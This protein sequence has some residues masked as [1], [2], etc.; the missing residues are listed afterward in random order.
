MVGASDEFVRTGNK[1]SASKKDGI[2]LENL[3]K[4]QLLKASISSYFI[5]LV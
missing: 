2:S 1:I 3:S 5:H 4:P